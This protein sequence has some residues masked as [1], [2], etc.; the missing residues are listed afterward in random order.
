MVH[1]QTVLL[2]HANKIGDIWLGPG[3]LHKD[4]IMHWKNAEIS[5]RLMAS[6]WLDDF[7]E[8]D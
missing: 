6:I 1:F 7:L 8:P 3:F 4:D 5:G 2:G